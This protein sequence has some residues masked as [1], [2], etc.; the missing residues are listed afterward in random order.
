MI[1]AVVVGTVICASAQGPSVVPFHRAFAGSDNYLFESKTVTISWIFL[2]QPPPCRLIGSFSKAGE[3]NNSP[4]E[5]KAMS[6]EAMHISL[7]RYGENLGLR[8]VSRYVS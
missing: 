4:N 1:G 3:Q 6:C 7:L 2:S 8:S 5:E